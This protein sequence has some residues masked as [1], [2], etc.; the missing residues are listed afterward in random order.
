MIGFYPSFLVIVL[1]TLVSAES[2]LFGIDIDISLPE[3]LCGSQN[4]AERKEW[5]VFSGVFRAN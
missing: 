1:G 4:I 5:F 2:S 3:Q